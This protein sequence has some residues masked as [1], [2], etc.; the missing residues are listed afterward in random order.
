MDSLDPAFQ[1]EAC[2]LVCSKVFW[3]FGGVLLIFS[4]SLGLLVWAIPG[5]RQGSLV[6]GREIEPNPSSCKILLK[7]AGPG[8][9]S[10][11]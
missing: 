8:M 9:A 3:A 7:S 10:V 1:R 2:S 4:C 5:G 11:V 6:Q